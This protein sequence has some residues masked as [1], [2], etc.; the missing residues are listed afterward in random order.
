MEEN[1][2]IEFSVSLVGADEV[3]K[4]L[5]QIKKLLNEISNIKIE[6]STN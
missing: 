5:E 1:K 3:I 4:K 6:V 2:T